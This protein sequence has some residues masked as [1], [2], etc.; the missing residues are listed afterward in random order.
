MGKDDLFAKGK[1]STKKKRSAKET[2]GVED[3]PLEDDTHLAEEV[4]ESVN[5]EGEDNVPDQLPEK[6]GLAEVIAEAR[7]ERAAEK[8]QQEN[9]EEE[10]DGFA[11]NTPGQS[12]VAK[13]TPGQS[14]KKKT[15]VQM[16]AAL[17]GEEEKADAPDHLAGLR[18]AIAEARRARA[19][20][21]KQEHGEEENDE[22][23]Y[24]LF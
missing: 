6:P 22:F 9:G 18:E 10:E 14:K 3:C 12:T 1:G 21:K 8:R 19:E 4:Q 7:K 20:R 24:D 17:G 13:K 2:G 16:A 23:D 15:L 11:K 5:G